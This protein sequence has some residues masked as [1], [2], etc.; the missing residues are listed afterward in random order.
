MSKE[1]KKELKE[2]IALDNFARELEKC[3]NVLELNERHLKALAESNAALHGDEEVIYS[4]LYQRIV[5][6]R[7]DI[8]IALRKAK[9]KVV[10]KD[11][12]EAAKEK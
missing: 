7:K 1:T 12:D 6:Q 8:K 5:A 9:R 11:A 10:K 3:D 2:E 4:P